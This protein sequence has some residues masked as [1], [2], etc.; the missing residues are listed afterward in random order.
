MVLYSFSDQ[1]NWILIAGIY[2]AANMENNPNAIC[3]SMNDNSSC[4]TINSESRITIIAHG[5]KGI[6]NDK[7]AISLLN[8]LEDIGL[9]EDYQGI[10]DLYSCFSGSWDVEGDNIKESIVDAI[11]D[12]YPNATVIGAVGPMIIDPNGK[13]H[14]VKPDKES[15]ETAIALQ[16]SLVNDD[17]RL[18]ENNLDLE[19][20]FYAQ[21]ADACDTTIE[22]FN[23]F[24]SALYDNQL[25]LSE[26][27]GMIIRQR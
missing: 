4:Q 2:H 5:E 24:L 1:G 17:L 18:L 7:N 11:A 3:K 9:R 22:F 16:V 6:V 23:R 12:R 8:Y 27:E 25:M 10:I 13:K 21:G 15:V 20:N 19:E 26:T 14:Y